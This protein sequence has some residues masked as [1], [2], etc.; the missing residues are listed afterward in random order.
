MDRRLAQIA[1]ASLHAYAAVLA[2]VATFL[3]V[4]ASIYHMRKARDL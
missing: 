2:V 3:H 1:F 4:G